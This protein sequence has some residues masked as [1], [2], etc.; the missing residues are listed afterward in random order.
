MDP[1]NN[2]ILYYGTNHLYKTT[3]G[4]GNWNSISPSLTDWT[5]GR[6]LGTITT[7]AVAPTNSEIIYVGTDDSH[8]WV[9]PDNGTS[10]NEIS[11]GL[12]FRWV[13][14]V[15]VDPTNQNIVY[16]TFNGLKWK[17][18]QPHVFRSTDMGA[19]WADISNN[20]PDAPIDAFAIDNITSTTLYL[21]NDVGMYVSFNSGQN[22]QVLGEGLPFLPIGDIEVHP[23]EHILVAGTYGRENQTV[24]SSFLLEQNYPNPFNPTTTIKYQIPASSFVT[25]KVYDVLGSEVAT[26]INEESA[27]GGAGTYEVEFSAT[28]G[29]TSLPSGIYFYK[30]QVYAP[31]RAGSFTETK[32]MILLK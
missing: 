11:D 13:T 30:L 16:V 20:L 3:N 15:A 9:S 1:N 10:W 21:G 26:L 31:G 19:N 14:R 18:P 22:W 4:A 12:P 23:T 32:K 7:I 27:T 2:N 29:A 24:A 8:V 6:R 28:G 5:P 25:I 17:D